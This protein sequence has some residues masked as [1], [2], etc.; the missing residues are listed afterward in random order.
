MKTQALCLPEG[1]VLRNSG[2]PTRLGEV[3]EIEPVLEFLFENIARFEGHGTIEAG[4]IL[5]TPREVLV[6]QSQRTNSDGIDELANIITDWGR[7]LREVRVPDG[8][9]HFKT[10]CSLFYSTTILS[11]KHLAN[12]CIFPTLK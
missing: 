4:D 7:V 9:L 12:S 1:V 8:V 11:T 5:T 10:D 3:E 2:A 6:G